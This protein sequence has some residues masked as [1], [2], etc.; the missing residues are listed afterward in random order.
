MPSC[1]G[2]AR[3]VLSGWVVLPVLA[4]AE[5]GVHRALRIIAGPSRRRG[6]APDSPKLPHAA[7]PL[8][9]QGVRA[10]KQKHASCQPSGISRPAAL[11]GSPRPA[12]PRRPFRASPRGANGSST[13]TPVG[14]KCRTVRVTTV[15]PCSIAVAAISRSVPSWPRVPHKRPQ[16]RAVD[17]STERTRSPYS[18]RTVSSH[19]A[20]TPANA[21]S[22]DCCLA[23]PR[24]ISATDTTLTYRSAVRCSAIHRPTRGFRTGLRSSDNTSVSTRNITDRPAG[25]AAEYARTPRR[26][27]GSRGAA[28]RTSVRWP[29]PFDGGVRTPAP[30]P[31]RRRAGRA[32]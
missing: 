14:S 2:S 32:A 27:A 13:G 8:P 3:W 19:A 17:A 20:R 30:Q 9:P 4:H 26:P 12:V 21:G 31:P 23:I 1:T 7:T 28:L 15:R 5:A 29:F 25:T 11:I 10:G 16:R 18:D 22:R 6:G 24:S